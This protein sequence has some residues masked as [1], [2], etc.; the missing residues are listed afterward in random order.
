MLIPMALMIGI[1]GSTNRVYAAIKF[2]LY[3]L[4][5]SLLMLVAIVATYQRYF[6]LTGVR[7]STVLQLAQPP[8]QQLG[9][10]A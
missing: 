8:L 10:T 4:G 7:R 3:T 2:F 5:G 9:M 6:D 1:W